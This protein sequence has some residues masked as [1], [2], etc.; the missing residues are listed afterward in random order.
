MKRTTL[1]VGAAI[2][3]T[4]V[5]GLYVALSP[6]DGEGGAS[7]VAKNA[8]PA[9]PVIRQPRAVAPSLPRDRAA[10]AAN[11]PRERTFGSVRVRD[12]R[13]GVHD[14]SDAAPIIQPPQSRKIPSQ[15]SYDIAQPVRAAAQACAASLPH[16]GRGPKPRFEGQITIAIHDHQATVTAAT[17]Q[18][19]D[20]TGIAVEPLQQCAEQKAI[21][22]SVPSG[23][24]P[25]LEGYS[26]TMSLRLLERQ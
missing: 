17:L 4:A 2:V 1:M 18:L 26:I 6:G 10:E 9:E 8:E 15:L 19:R 23:D 12:H 20:V 3:L 22:V 11:P 5:V 21:G 7:P 14:V 13:S 25:D 16:D 24:E